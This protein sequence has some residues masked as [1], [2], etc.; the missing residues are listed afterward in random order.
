[1]VKNSYFLAVIVYCFFRKFQ[2]LQ[3]FV[4]LVL[5]I[6]QVV[7]VVAALFLTNQDLSAD[8]VFFLQSSHDSLNY[9]VAIATSKKA[10]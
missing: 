9:E 10:V 5:F 4:F 8:F 7:M 3:A 2:T 6:L 1:M